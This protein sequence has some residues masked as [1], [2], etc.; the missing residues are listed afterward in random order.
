MN[1]DNNFL[2]SASIWAMYMVFLTLTLSNSLKT[3]ALITTTILLLLQPD[4]RQALHQ[5]LK[6]PWCRATFVL[7]GIILLACF[8]SP[9][10]LKLKL[11]LLNKY[12][13]LLYLPLFVV[14]FRDKKM[15]DMAIYAFLTGMFITGCAS[16]LPLFHIISRATDAGTVFH[17]HLTTGYFMA[18][19]AF[20]AY[21]M[22]QQFKGYRRLGLQ[23]L[24]VLF[25]LHTLLLN[26]GRTGYVVWLACVSVLILQGRVWRKIPYY[27]WLLLIIAGT[28][29]YL[30][31]LFHERVMLGFKEI[32]Q[33]WH[34]HP[35]GSIGFRLQF[36][37][38]AATLFKMHPWWG[39]GTGSFAYYFTQDQPIPSWGKH[40]FDPHNQYALML[41]EC[42]V[43]GLL[44]LL[45]YFLATTLWVVRAY[46][47][48]YL[49]MLGLIGSFVVANLFDSFLLYA[50]TGYFFVFFAALS[51][52]EVYAAAKP[53]ALSS[54]TYARRNVL[55]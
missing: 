8:Y 21:L 53:K 40:L 54:F 38:Y 45:Y 25:S 12:S 13:K 34:G 30:S 37:Q 16:L 48:Y 7:F 36:L 15:R 31:P 46:H 47:E 6:M 11:I 14:A 44:C 4:V 26:P 1:P 5:S 19:G 23:S 41:V 43:L 20:L 42:G 32:T 28:S 18:F 9:A 2:K 35:D 39:S 29:I 33:F 27:C 22:S 52:G 3:I 55:C 24:A 51:L 17:N 50:S 49:L 10:E